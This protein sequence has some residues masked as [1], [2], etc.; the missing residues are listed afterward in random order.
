M[1][2]RGLMSA[3]PCGLLPQTFGVRYDDCMKVDG[4]PSSSY[5]LK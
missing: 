2:A 3:S 5:F 4:L 1:G